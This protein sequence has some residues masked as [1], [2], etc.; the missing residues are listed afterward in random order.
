M[1]REGK[2][3][4]CGKSGVTG[5]IIGGEDFHYKSLAHFAKTHS[6][7]M[8]NT[9]GHTLAHSRTYMCAI[10]TNSLIPRLL[11]FLQCDSV[12]Y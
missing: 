11:E 7:R 9:E 6:G 4:F 5:R 3:I 12:Q 10:H 2:L 1:A 8:K